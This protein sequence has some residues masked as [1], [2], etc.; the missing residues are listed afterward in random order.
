M[1]WRELGECCREAQRWRGVGGEFVV[2]AAEVLHEGVAGGDPRGR[3]EPFQPAHRPQPGLQPAVIGFD[4]VV[5]VLLGDV[6]GGRDQFVE[7]PQVWAGPGR[8]S[9]RPAPARAQRPGEEPPGGGSVPLLG[10]QDV[11]DLADTGR[12]PGTGTATGR[13]P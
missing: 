12:P 10:Q 9:P 6:R 1:A 8:W 5:R 7:H 3:A 13:R 11:D 2:A 4:P